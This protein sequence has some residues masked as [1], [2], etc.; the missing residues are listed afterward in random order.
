MLPEGVE[1][2]PNRNGSALGM[3]FRREE[4]FVFVMPGVPMEMKGMIDDTVIP[5]LRE[6]CPECRVQVDFIRTT[7]LA[8]S[9]I[10][11]K[12]ENGLSQFTSFEIA[13]LPKFAGVD[14]RV[15]R[16]DEDIPNRKKF[17][18]FLKLL[19]DQIGDAIYARE[20]IELEEVLGKLLRERKL[21]ISMAES[22]TGGLVQH[23]LTQIPG[24]SHYFM[25]GVVS[26]SN[27]AKMEL[28][29]V[30]ESSL[31]K[32]GAV[33]EQ[34]AQEMAEGVRKRFGTDISISTTGIAGPTGATASKP[35]GLVYLA[36]S[37]KDK[38]IAQKRLFIQDRNSV[39]QRSAQAALELARRYLLRLPIK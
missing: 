35:V 8:E 28:L 24:S 21:T 38:L 27:Q 14:L 25:G 2:I 32:Y 13:F 5:R 4:K 33:S 37:A 17:E 10:Y 31:K 22:L 16:K 19:D 23:K 34:V 6:I 18:K 36:L 26:Y 30:K 39:K 12:I 29:G 1:L 15:V 3:I 9:V 11:Q 7:G 20:D